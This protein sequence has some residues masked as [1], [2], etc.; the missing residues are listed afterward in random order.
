[1]QPTVRE[2]LAELKG[3]G[4]KVTIENGNVRVAYAVPTDEVRAVR[5]AITAL[6]QHKAQLVSL[7]QGA[8]LSPQ[9]AMAPNIPAGTILIAPRYD[10]SAVETVPNCWCCQVPYK[11]DRI[12]EWE[13]KQ[14]A[15]LDPGCR[16]LD[17]AQAIKCCGLCTQHCT[18]K[19]R[20]EG[21]NC[22][23]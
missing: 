5:Q 17:T 13:G 19:R 22:P 3:H 6:K 8:A 14:Y 21:N 18:C 7:L 4:A 20:H 23:R 12:Q 10:T 9:P 1:M 2:I 11:L 15:H 16:C